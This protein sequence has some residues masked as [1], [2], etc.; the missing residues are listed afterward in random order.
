MTDAL[1]LAEPLSPTQVRLFMP[2]GT[3]VR[4]V[5]FLP[6]KDHP[7]EEGAGILPVDLV[8][9]SRGRLGKR[10]AKYLLQRWV[11]S[12]LC[13]GLNKGGLSPTMERRARRE[14][15]FVAKRVRAEVVT[16]ESLVESGQASA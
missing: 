16:R 11:L 4:V 1:S 3:I 12:A 10:R 9:E 15:A 5:K 14:S 2:H 8:W 7:F 13:A 6:I